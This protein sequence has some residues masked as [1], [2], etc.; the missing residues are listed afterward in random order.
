MRSRQSR[1]FQFSPLDGKIRSELSAPKIG[2]A[3]RIMKDERLPWVF[4][5]LPAVCGGD[6][7]VCLSPSLGSI[8][9]LKSSASRKK[10]LRLKRTLRPGAG[11][12]SGDVRRVNSTRSMI[13]KPP[14]P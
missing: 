4:S 5:E 14:K 13:A 8:R 1:L 2:F 3:I 10:R 11:I 9:D 6:G 12:R 7:G